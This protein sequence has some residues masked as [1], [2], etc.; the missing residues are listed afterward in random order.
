MPF[1]RP[2]RPVQASCKRR[3]WPAVLSIGS[4]LSV[5]VPAASWAQT[6]A[7]SNSLP[8][9]QVS[10]SASI[11][12]LP[13]FAPLVKTV[14]PAVVNVSATQ[15]PM[16]EQGQEAPD[17]GVSP[18][19][20]PSPFDEFLRKFFEQQGQGGVPVLPDAQRVALGS[21]FII[22]PSGY[23]VT[24]NHVVQNARMVTV[25]FQDDTR[26][27]AKIIG[28]DPKMDLALLKIDAKESLP[29]VQWGD[30]NAAQVGDWVV[31]VGNP[32]GLG[33]TVSSGIISALGRDI[34]SGPYDDFL[35]IDASINRGDSG[36]PTFNLSG[37]VIG[38]NTAIYS[39]NGGSVGIGFAIPS[40]LAKPVIEQLREHGKVER[41]WLGVE[42][43]GVTPEIARSVGLPKA[44]G[45][46]ITD[47][48]EGSPAAKAGFEQGD[49][50]LSFKG[51]A[52]Q[53]AR[54]LPIAVAET[55]IG[56]EAEVTVWRKGSEIAL[57][58]VIAATP[59]SSPTA[60]AEQE[61][62][63]E[64]HTSAMGLKLAPLTQERRRQLHVGL[65]VKGVIVAAVAADSPLAA[66][67]IA[68][69]DIIESI[70]QQ[71]VT[72]PKEASA[73]LDRAQKGKGGQQSLLLLINRGGVN[74]YIA[75]SADN[76]NGN[77][78]HSP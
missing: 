64:E 30:S 14:L 11:A 21:G 36:G 58:P 13:S 24:N 62:G 26:H 53:K 37:Q 49:V 75:M 61:G 22:D 71:P 74:E 45:A 69:G 35:Q 43:Q 63:A 18:G 25:V 17:Q 23:V 54:D 20:P 27:P 7:Q 65:N 33:G 51:H 46:I 66:I 42:V 77:G 47:V 72:S 31:A 34:H 4:C 15:N 3:V 48:T 59:E 29:Y 19:L 56:D 32:F 16:N 60:R 44:E 5:V 40:S 52:V 50:I 2:A 9:A 67:G 39:P 1:R 78:G 73:I 70:N 12:Q 38:I 10:L 57:Q 55:P 68:A 28:R 6:N 8:P 76:I 41:G